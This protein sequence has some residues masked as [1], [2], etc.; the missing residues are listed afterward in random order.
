MDSHSLSSHFCIFNCSVKKKTMECLVAALAGYILLWLYNTSHKKLIKQLAQFLQGKIAAL[1]TP[2][3]MFIRDLNLTTRSTNIRMNKASGLRLV[4]ESVNIRNFNYLMI[5]LVHL[6]LLMLTSKL[7]I[8]SSK[9]ITSSD[10]DFWHLR[11]SLL[12]HIDYYLS[13]V[14][15]INCFNTE[16]RV[17]TEEKRV[18]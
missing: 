14:L 3:R 15:I 8:F 9:F 7:A 1:T 6:S 18:Y 16:L 17:W 5:V 11:L 12:I 10:L 13:A 2:D 4:I